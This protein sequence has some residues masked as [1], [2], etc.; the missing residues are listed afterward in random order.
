MEIK[1]EV[2]QGTELERTVKETELRYNHFF[3]ILRLKKGKTMITANCENLP[4]LDAGINL[5]NIGASLLLESSSE[6]TLFFME[7]NSKL[8]FKKEGEQLR[9]SCSFGEE[10]IK[11]DFNKYL[12]AVERFYKGLVYDLLKIS[13]VLVGNAMFLNHFVIP[14]SFI[15]SSPDYVRKKSQT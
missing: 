5:I 12:K 1:F 9:I 7:N 10:E 14:Y 6:R 11:E 3:G 4:L 15:F 13:P 2:V 8:Y